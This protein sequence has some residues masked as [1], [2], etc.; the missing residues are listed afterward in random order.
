MGDSS[1]EA[2]VAIH[3]P[4]S[5]TREGLGRGREKRGCGGRGGGEKHKGRGCDGG[6]QLARGAKGGW[7]KVGREVGVEQ[8]TG[9]RHRGL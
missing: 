7:P 2:E 9:G 6:D 1:P 8:E 3:R 5:N 4:S